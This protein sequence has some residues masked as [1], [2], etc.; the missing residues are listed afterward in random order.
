MTV[1]DYDALNVGAKLLYDEAY[2]KGHA[3]AREE[4]SD[5]QTRYQA[6]GMLL[7][8]RVALSA[9][10][11]MRANGEQP[12]PVDVMRMAWHALQRTPLIYIEEPLRELE[13]LMPASASRRPIEQPEAEQL[14]RILSMVSEAEEAVR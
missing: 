6:Q 1:I 10:V 5:A 7:I 3:A 13:R 14:D 9:A 2:R 8:A 4:R 12:T 11:R